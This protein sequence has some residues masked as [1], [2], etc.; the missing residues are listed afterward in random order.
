MDTNI[1]V[2]QILMSCKVQAAEDSFS[3]FSF[4]LRHRLVIYIHGMVNLGKLWVYD[5]MSWE[6]AIWMYRSEVWEADSRTFLCI[7][8]FDHGLSH[9]VNSLKV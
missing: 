4:F 1:I 5:Y 9:L 3:S 2:K 6:M 7:A 8:N